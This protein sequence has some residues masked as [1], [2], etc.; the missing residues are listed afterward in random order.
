MSI[1]LGMDVQGG[2]AA[3]RTLANGADVIV[4]TANQLTQALEG[5]AWHGND[6]NRTREEWR[7]Q[8]VTGLNQVADQIRAYAAMIERQAQEQEAASSQ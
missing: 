4:Q 5:F 2:H 7:G 3:S 8:Y 1:L 6:A